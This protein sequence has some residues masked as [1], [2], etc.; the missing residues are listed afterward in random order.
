MPVAAL[1][2]VFALGTDVL[3]ADA[4]PR[5]FSPWDQ[6]TLAGLA[7]FG[8]LYLSGSLRLIARGA[9]RSRVEPAAFATGWFA[10]VAAVVPWFDAAAIERFS[11]H[12]AQ[13][14]LMM[15]VAAPL[16]MVGRPMSTLLWALPERWRLALVTPFRLSPVATTLRTLTAPVVAWS[17]HGAAIW[18]WHVPILYEA[19]VRSEAM[20][21][22]QHGMFVAT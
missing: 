16:L 5:V 12:M 15:L 7:I 21:A 9:R 11:A 13:H 6:T 10:L 8:A 17:L 3:H 4:D 14:E 22:V 1:R 19:A 2:T 20:H 18:I